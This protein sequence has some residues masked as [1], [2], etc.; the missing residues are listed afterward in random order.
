MTVP[1]RDGT[2]ISIKS[3]SPLTTREFINPAETSEYLQ[4]NR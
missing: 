4:D 2:T 3:F 1:E